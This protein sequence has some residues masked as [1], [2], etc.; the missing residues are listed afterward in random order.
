MGKETKKNKVENERYILKKERE[1]EKQ[2]RNVYHTEC[3]IS[4][5]YFHIVRMLEKSDKIFGTFCSSK[6]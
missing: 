2:N 1:T 5:V 6:K 3:S 4:L